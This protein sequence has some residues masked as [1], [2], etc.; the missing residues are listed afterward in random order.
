MGAELW[1]PLGKTIHDG[2][3]RFL[4]HGYSLN[5]VDPGLKGHWPG[6]EPH[7]KLIRKECLFPFDEEGNGGTVINRL[8]NLLKV[9]EHNHLL[10]S[11]Y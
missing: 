10:R 8:S 11:D 6:E 3:G 1:V 4:P 9:G 2:D 5:S 7:D